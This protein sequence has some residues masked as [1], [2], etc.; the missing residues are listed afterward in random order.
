MCLISRDRSAA[1]LKQ[2]RNQ[3]RQ[4]REQH[5]GL[6]Q[7]TQTESEPR[8]RMLDR[9]PGQVREQEPTYRRCCF[10]LEKRVQ[11][12]FLDSVGAKLVSLQSEQ[13][14]PN[15]KMRRN[16]YARNH[17][18]A[19]Q[20]RPHLHGHDRRRIHAICEA[21]PKEVTPFSLRSLLSGSSLPS[22]STRRNKPWV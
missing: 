18:E 21:L 22:F 16:E 2:K 6:N 17:Q 15:E 14:Q 10:T 7:T 3:L 13:P 12:K 11:P 19:I 5:R 20:I 9:V 4:T 8:Q 1:S